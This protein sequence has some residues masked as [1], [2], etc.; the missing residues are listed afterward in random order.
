MDKAQKR[1]R[2]M[3]KKYPRIAFAAMQ[4]STNLIW[5]SAHDNVTAAGPQ[6]L[7]VRSNTL[8]SNIKGRVMQS[9]SLTVG[10]VGI[11]PHV[12]YG[13][14]HELGIGGRRKRPWLSLAYKVNKKKV[15]LRFERLTKDLLKAA[16]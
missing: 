3:Q 6:L 13:R 7:N 1:L 11:P 15:Q 12:S 5:G 2:D 10:T 8:R 14:D 9:G 16:R 4:D